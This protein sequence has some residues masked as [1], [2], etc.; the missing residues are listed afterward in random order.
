MVYQKRKALGDITT[1]ALS[2]THPYHSS[3]DDDDASGKRQVRALSVC[4]S[5]LS[6]L[7]FPPIQPPYH[8][9]PSLSIH[10][11][12]PTQTPPSPPTMP[13]SGTPPAA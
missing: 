2:G 4:V 8:F 9:P 6:P 3:T 13:S 5:P 7:A 1:A 11:S 12:A 10:Y